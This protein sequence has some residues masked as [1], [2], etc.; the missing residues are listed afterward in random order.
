MSTSSITSGCLTWCRTAALIV[1]PPMLAEVDPGLALLKR[2]AEGPDRLDV[3]RG[4]APGV[5]CVVRRVPL[6]ID[7]AVRRSGL[8]VTPGL[9]HLLVKGLGAGAQQ[10]GQRRGIPPRLP[11]CASIRLRRRCMSSSA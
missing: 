4:T 3:L 8:T 6:R 1:V 9:H 7:R 11:R 10:Q 2:L 5:A